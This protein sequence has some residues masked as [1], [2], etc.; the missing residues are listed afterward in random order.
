MPFLLPFVGLSLWRGQWWL[1]WKPAICFSRTTAPST[2]T[3]Q[4]PLGTALQQTQNCNERYVYTEYSECS[5]VM[6]MSMSV[7]VSFWIIDSQARRKQHSQNFLFQLR[8]M[9]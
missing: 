8:V 7:R 5:T 2:A 6:P 9:I 1:I 3:R 4:A